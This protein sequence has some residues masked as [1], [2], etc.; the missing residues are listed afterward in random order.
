MASQT[1]L[2]NIFDEL[3]ELRINY[4]TDSLYEKYLE[5]SSK[6]NIEKY[7]NYSEVRVDDFKDDVFHIVL[8][9][10]VSDET[11]FIP[12]ISVLGPNQKE[13]EELARRLQKEGKERIHY[14]YSSF[15]ESI[16]AAKER[17]VMRVSFKTTCGS[18]SFTVSE[19][20]MIQM[21]PS[22]VSLWFES[23]E[24]DDCEESTESLF[25]KFLLQDGGNG[26]FAYEIAKEY[27]RLGIKELFFSIY[28]FDA[29]FDGKGCLTR[30]M[31][32]GTDSNECTY[33]LKRRLDK[34]RE[35]VS[36][37]R[38]RYVS[39]LL[40]KNAFEA[41]KSAKTAIMSR[42]MSH[43]LGSHVMAYLKQKLS[44]VAAITSRDNNVLRN[45]YP[46]D[47]PGESVTDVEFPFLVGL[48]K[49][50]G[51]L[52]ERQDYIATIATDYIPYG[53]PVNMK[54]AIYDELNPDLRY[55]RHKDDTK[56]RPLNIL[57]SYIAKSEGLTRE[58]MSNDFVTHN[59]ILFTFV[60]YKNDKREYFGR[61]PNE[62]DSKN[63][64]LKEMRKINF[65]LPGGLVGR[66][67]FFSIIENLI[68]NAA[69]HGNRRS[70]SSDRN[71]R[72]EFDVIDGAI[73][74][75]AEEAYFSESDKSLLSFEQ[76]SLPQRLSMKL[77]NLY[78]DAE[79]IKDL[80]LITITD[81]LD[82]SGNQRLIDRLEE[83]IG[84]DY[85]EKDGRMKDSNKGIKELRISSAWMRGES[86]E[87][88][89][90]CVNKDNSCRPYAP[91][92]SVELTE[93]YHLR[94]VFAL[95]KDRTVGYLRG[96][97][98]EDV[99]KRFEES[100]PQKWHHFDSIEEIKSEKN[101]YRYILVPPELYD[102]VR[103]YVSNRLIKWE[104]DPCLAFS[105]DITLEDR[106]RR[107]L[108][109]IYEKKTGICAD[110]SPCIY[111]WDKKTSEEVVYR[112]EK[113][114]D[115]ILISGASD[116]DD[117][118]AQYAYRTHHSTF[119]DYKTYWDKKRNGTGYGSIVSIDAIT[120]DNSSDRLV[121][122]E[123]LDEQ[124]YYSHLFALKQ[125]VAI[126][127][128]R[129]FR[130]THLVDE[131]LFTTCNND[132]DAIRE[133]LVSGSISLDDAIDSLI[134]KGVNYNEIE[135]LDSEKLVDYIISNSHDF[136]AQHIESENHFTAF[137]IGRLVDIFT[138]VEDGHNG[139]AIVGCTS[140]SH[141]PTE[142]DKFAYVF[143]RIATI[144]KDD[145]SISIEFADKSFANKFNYISIHQGL[146]DKIY[147]C[148]GIK[149]QSVTNDDLKQ[150]VTK[151]LYLHLMKG[152]T[153][154]IKKDIGD[155]NDTHYYEYLPN[156][157][158]HSGR[159]KPSEVDMPQHQPF[160]QFSAI[161]HATKDCKYS[162]VQ[163]LD[164][165]RYE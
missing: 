6:I 94:Y 161:E 109:R 32:I 141:S 21:T 83:G 91:I 78:R 108:I 11:P 37:I 123:P 38:T 100:D 117:S 71:L 149:D 150:A 147:T 73:L 31:L 98:N 107:T 19:C 77:F 110:K 144:R 53:A 155:E 52:Q 146:L 54:D 133:S 26:C 163:V 34:I 164:F 113:P 156:F 106:E 122:R 40:R 27:Y 120:G 137:N 134:E 4:G 129:I 126:I 18:Q 17:S 121:R 68:R 43:N 80:F 93:D 36:Y 130:N 1:E 114:F 62:C 143:D 139:F 75:D 152:D 9:V 115:K 116:V 95:C 64:A 135:N 153:P 82:Y 90:R 131:S 154:I 65:S 76:I 85:I 118:I 148:F 58:N 79:D 74:N 23:Q 81:N 136:T 157:I 42:N 60:S 39:D 96:I 61:T 69:K 29:S 70:L 101:S 132:L 45:F 99:F 104:D 158:I 128:E 47:E 24:K 72:F 142:P 112:E 165:A 160:V 49:F 140:C 8:S 25:K 105:D 125:R 111:I 89:F 46:T 15:L 92:V 138:I 22:K 145:S 151:A 28:S 55:I 3:R 87:E 103:P 7:V 86:N 102:S 84:E 41:T 67:A 127:D 56:N 44:S 50:I 119:S 88:L 59:D 13:L 16:E 57:L 66:Q 33:Y 48:G 51:Y 97:A 124:W 162:L 14:N 10:K 12:F 63:L 20:R 35:I 2:S 5:V 30:I 159:S